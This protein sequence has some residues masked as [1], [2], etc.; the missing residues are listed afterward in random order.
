MIDMPCPP[1][2]LQAGFAG[3]VQIMEVFYL[4]NDNNNKNNESK[5]GAGLY[6]RVKA[7]STGT[8]TRRR[9]AA[10]PPR[11]KPA[12]QVIGGETAPQARER[13]EQ[14]PRPGT[15]PQSAPQR[16]RAPRAKQPSQ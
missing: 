15:A 13:S 5:E 10:K 3:Y 6:G 7:P 2:R 12:D 16:G 11:E 14:A 1:H 4:T 8:Q 9:P